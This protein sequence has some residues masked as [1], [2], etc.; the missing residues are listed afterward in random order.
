MDEKM[1]N[2]CHQNNKKSLLIHWIENQNNNTNELNKILIGGEASPTVTPEVKSHVLGFVDNWL[3]SI[4]TRPYDANAIDYNLYLGAQRRR[5]IS[6]QPPLPPFRPHQRFGVPNNP[7]INPPNLAPTPVIVPIAS[8]INRAPT[9]INTI[10]TQ[11]NRAPTQNL[12]QP[13]KILSTSTFIGS[14]IQHTVPSSKIPSELSLTGTTI[15]TIPTSVSQTKQLNEVPAISAPI[16]IVINNTEP[17]KTLPRL[18]PEYR[19]VN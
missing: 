19:V 1:V 9:Q 18:V 12:E 15:P 16:N 6:K 4:L 14:E 5:I 13:P 3:N 2:W 10:P 17:S 7:P 11:I 8:Q